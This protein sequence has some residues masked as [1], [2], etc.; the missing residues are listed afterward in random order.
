MAD[1]DVWQEAVKGVRRIRTNC[2]TDD[3]EPKE[4]KIR[5]D[6]EV[7]VTFEI[8]KS[9]KSVAKDDFSQMDGAL[10]KRFKREE[11]KV[12]A[13]L[14]L[15]GTTERAAFE[16]VCDFIKAAYNSG[17]RCVLIVTGKGIDDT[18]FSTKGV[19]RK[20]VLNWLSHSEISPL[21]LGFKNPAEAKGG[22]GAL[23]I[24]LR[25]KLDAG[26]RKLFDFE[27]W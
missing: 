21:I 6:K 3:I 17:K 13:V 22:A 4:I 26:H 24:L 20:S 9:G 2:H 7:T 15:H 5:K 1:S 14:D 16:Q 11:F 8:L 10:A 23:Y 27:R 18:L 25:K 12:E 19:L